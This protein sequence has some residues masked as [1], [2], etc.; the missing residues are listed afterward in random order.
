[1]LLTA[2]AVIFISEARHTNLR[3]RADRLHRT[4]VTLVRRCATGHQGD[5]SDFNG[6]PHSVLNE[7]FATEETPPNKETPQ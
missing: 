1:M 5:P 7:A 4:A 3:R 2:L 6:V